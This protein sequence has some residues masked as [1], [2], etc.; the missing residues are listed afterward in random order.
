MLVIALTGGIGSGKTTASDIFKTKHIPVIDT[1][2]IA[3]EIIEPGQ[4]AYTD[5]IQAFGQDILDQNKNINRQHLRKIVFNNTNKRKQL[6]N[7]LHPIIWDNVQKQVTSLKQAAGVPAY[8][9]V[10]VPLLFENNTAKI[11]FNRILLIDTPEELQV[12]RTSKRDNTDKE[13]V[14][15]I[16]STQVSRKTRIEAADD[17]I[18]NIGDIKFLENEIEK[19]HQKYLKLSV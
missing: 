14:E 17:I 19:L 13:L 2:I 7:I 15:K 10:V 16:I 12:N 3:R 1:D 9:I 18:E 11:P 8:C 5:V 4:P 6:E